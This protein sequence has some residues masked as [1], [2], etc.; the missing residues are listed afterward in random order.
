MIALLLLLIFV[1]VSNPYARNSDASAYMLMYRKISTTTTSMTISNNEHISDNINLRS[2]STNSTLSGSGSSS[3]STDGSTRIES[4]AAVEGMHT[5]PSSS[6]LDTSPLLTPPSYSTDQDPHPPVSLTQINSQINSHH[7]HPGFVPQNQ[8]QTQFQNQNQNQNNSYP[9]TDMDP[10]LQPSLELSDPEPDSESEPALHLETFDG[11]TARTLTTTSTTFATAV[12][13]TISNITGTTSSSSAVSITFSNSFTPAPVN[14]LRTSLASFPNIS[15]IPQYIRDDV[16]SM[17]KEAL[18]K[19]KNLEIL[20]N[21]LE[22]KITWKNVVRTIVISRKETLRKLYE[23]MW[24][25]FGI[26]DDP[27]F[28]AQKPGP[29]SCSNSELIDATKIE[30]NDAVD[31]VEAMADPQ[32]LFNETVAQQMRLR[33]YNSSAKIVTDCFDFSMHSKSLESLNFSSYR[34][35]LLET[36]NS[37]DVFEVYYSDGFDVLIEEYDHDECT[38]RDTRTVRLPKLGTLSDLRGTRTCCICFY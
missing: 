38:F 15:D 22:L 19:Q 37:T 2:D 26:V 1:T 20:H 7:P 27:D 9:H 18:E 3:S 12:A 23:M 30:I 13:T 6:L 36:K 31:N 14:V 5:I 10:G 28:A 33:F 24:S 34:H 29:F 17:E 25:L 32:R 16:L 11:D 35:L 8:N 4:V 21:L